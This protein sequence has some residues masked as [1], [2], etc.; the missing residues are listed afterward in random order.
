[1]LTLDESI[2]A[3]EI[4]TVDLLALDEALTELHTLESRLCRVVELKFFAGLNID[5]MAQALGVSAATIERD[6]TVARAWLH[7]RLFS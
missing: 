4:A 6:W 7:Q 2:P 5:E 3:P 1:V